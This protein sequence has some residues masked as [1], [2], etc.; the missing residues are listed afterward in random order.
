MTRTGHGEC[1]C[2]VRLV[3]CVEFVH[4]PCGFVPAKLPLVLK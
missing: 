1:V 3:C 2:L 4:E